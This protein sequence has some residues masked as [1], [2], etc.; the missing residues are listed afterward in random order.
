MAGRLGKVPKDRLLGWR[1]RPAARPSGC[2]RPTTAWPV[3]GRDRSVQ[4]VYWFNWASEYDANSEA[5]DVP[6]RFS[7][8]TRLAQ[9]AFTP[10]PILRTYADVAARYE[11]CQ[12]RERT[13]ALSASGRQAGDGQQRVRGADDR[14]EALLR[15]LG[16]AHRQLRAAGLVGRAGDLVLQARGAGG[17]EVDRRHGQPAAAEAHRAGAGLA[18]LDPRLLQA[19]EVDQRVGDG[20]KRSS[21]SSRSTPRSATSRAAAI[22]RWTSILACS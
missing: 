19:D 13:G 22:R 12:G 5:A 1:R 10:Q 16:D 20:P 9:N 7:G 17:V 14:R 2:T 4:Q 15:V 8:L 3:S 6:F 11:G 21:S 18:E